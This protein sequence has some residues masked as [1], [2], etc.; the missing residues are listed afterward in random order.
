[1]DI[2]IEGNSKRIMIIM[3]NEV[4][5]RLYSSSNII[6]MIYLRRIKW[7]KCVGLQFIAK[8]EMHMNF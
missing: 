4:L 5:H 6:K 8:Q 7:M 3:H 2:T 1:L